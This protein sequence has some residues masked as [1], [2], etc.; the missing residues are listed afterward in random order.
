MKNVLYLSSLCS[1]EEYKKMFSKYGTTSSHA[2]QKFNRLFVKG[3]IE[4]NCE[5]YAISQKIVLNEQ[6]VKKI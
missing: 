5:V 3:L 1:V 4:N 2:S 6:D